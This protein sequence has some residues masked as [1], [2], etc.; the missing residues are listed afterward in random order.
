LVLAVVGPEGVHAR[1]FARAR[2]LQ[3]LVHIVAAGSIGDPR[4]LRPEVERS[5]TV[6]HVVLADSHRRF[7]SFDIGGETWRAILATD[8]TDGGSVRAREAGNPLDGLYRRAARRG[9]RYNLESDRRLYGFCGSFLCRSSSAS[10][11]AALLSASICG[12]VSFFADGESAF[13][14]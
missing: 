7:L 2:I 4:G 8:R 3:A 13:E 14:V 12:G 10:R 6:G 1:R 9:R 5:D 11:I